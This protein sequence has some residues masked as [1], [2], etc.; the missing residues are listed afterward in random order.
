MT[1]ST[2]TTN[3]SDAMRAAWA[4]RRAKAANASRHASASKKAAGP[5]KTP[6]KRTAAL[7]GLKCCC[8]CGETTKK[9][10]NFL[11]GHDMRLKGMLIRG[12]VSKEAIERQASVAFLQEPRWRDLLKEAK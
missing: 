11:P 3:R 6:K 12:K 1:T 4:T 10:R 2:K 9:G 5:S 7:S 8:G